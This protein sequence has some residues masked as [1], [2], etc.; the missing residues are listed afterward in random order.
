MFGRLVLTLL[1]FPDTTARLHHCNECLRIFSLAIT[2][3]S[4]IVKTAD[5]QCDNVEPISSGG[6]TFLQRIFFQ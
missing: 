4:R 1:K 5:I 3:I 2:N 6:L